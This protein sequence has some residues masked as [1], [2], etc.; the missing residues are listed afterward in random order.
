[1]F[2]NILLGWLHSSKF[3]VLNL[4]ASLN[5]LPLSTIFYMNIW[6]APCQQTQVVFCAKNSA[7]MSVDFILKSIHHTSA[8]WHILMLHVFSTHYLVDKENGKMEV[9]MEMS[10]LLRIELSIIH[11]CHTEDKYSISKVSS[12]WI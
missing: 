6:T 10:N 1:M 7:G 11:T 12:N 5:F 4:W 9:R 8:F 2:I 3:K